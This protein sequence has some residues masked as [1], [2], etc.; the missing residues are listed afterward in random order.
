MN[1]TTSVTQSDRFR[2]ATLHPALYGLSLLALAAFFSGEAGLGLIVTPPDAGR[3]EITWQG[4]VNVVSFG[5]LLHL[6]LYGLL[7]TAIDQSFVRLDR[8]GIT[9]RDVFLQP[10]T[11]PWNRVDRIQGPTGW[12]TLA[13]GYR[14]AQGRGRTVDLTLLI[15][16]VYQGTI[17]AAVRR[18]RPELLAG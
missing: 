12:T 4:L 2:S 7:S 6:A 13:V 9:Y 17:D 5:F 15:G 14:D 10:Q 3:Y 16:P 11:I 18:Y 8:E 1:P